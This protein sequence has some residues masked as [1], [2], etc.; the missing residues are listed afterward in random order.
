MDA[1]PENPEKENPEKEYPER[2][3]RSALGRY[4]STIRVTEGCGARGQGYIDKA[5]E[6]L[7]EAW[8]DLTEEQQKEHSL[9]KKAVCYNDGSFGFGSGMAEF[10]SRFGRF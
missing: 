9:P 10:G 3:Y 8:N 2:E 1:R 5:Y 4:N 6:D 7:K